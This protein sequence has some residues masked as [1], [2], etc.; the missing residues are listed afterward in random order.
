MLW[1]TAIVLSEIPG[2][3]VSLL[4]LKRVVLAQ[5]VRSPPMVRLHFVQLH[6]LP[7]LITFFATLS[8]LG[9]LDNLLSLLQLLLILLVRFV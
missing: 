3:E 2:A 9:R 1:D 6:R 8:D 4:L 7:P 5:N